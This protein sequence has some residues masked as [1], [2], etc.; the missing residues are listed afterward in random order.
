MRICIAKNE[1]TM[2]PKKS[3]SKKSPAAADPSTLPLVAGQD[4]RRQAEAQLSERKEKTASLPATEA[5]TQ[6]L[7]HELQVHQIELEMQ[8]EELVQARAEMEA[9]LRQYTDL[10]DFAPV[11]YFTLA[12]DGTISKVNLAG[13][14]LLGLEHGQLIM[15]RLGIFVCAQ[16]R[17][18]LSAF[19]D[20]VFSSGKKESCEIELLKAGSAPF[21]VY[22][23]AATDSTERKTCRAVVVDISERKQEEEISKQEQALSNAIIEAIPGTFY[24]LDEIGQYVRWNAYQRDEIVGKPDDLVGSTNAL[25]TIH[26]DDRALIQS[27]I[28]NVLAND[29][30]ETIEGRVLLR[31]GPAFRWLLMT[32]RRMLIDNR[33]FLVGI[34][35]DISARK[36]AEEA[37]QKTNQDYRMLSENSPDLIARFDT[38]LRHLYVNPAAAQ[39]GKLSADEYTGLTIAETGVDEPTA[40]IWEQRL[41]QVLDTGKM[42]D[43]VDSFPTPDGNHY[44]NTRFVPELAP[45]GSICSILSVARDIT[46]RKQAEE[47][48]AASEGELRAL[49]AAMT[50]V[51]IVYGADG[52][53]TKIALTNPINHYRPLDDMLGKTVHDILPKEQANYIVAKIDEAIQTGRVV[54]GEYT[55]QLGGKEIWFA[56]SASRLSENTAVWVA[57]DIT[58]RKQNEQKLREYSEHLEEMVAERTRELTDAQEKLVRQEKLAVLGQLAGGVGHELRNPLAVINAAIYYLKL[59]QPDASDKVRE[60][61]A[62]IE[63]EVRNS[64][65]IITDLLDFA[66]IKSVDREAVSVS[67]IVQRV[68][69]RYPVPPSVTLSL[70]LSPYLPKIYADPRH[71]EQVLGNLVLN[72]CQAMK[73]GGQ[74]SVISRQASV[75][76]DQLP[77]PNPQLLIIVRDTGVGISPENMSKLFEPLF[78]TKIKGIG[79]G[80]AISKKLIEANGGRIEVESEPGKGST[81]TLVLPAKED[82]R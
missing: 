16:S 19:L 2:S 28:V 74:L 18:T 11:G 41:R 54:T 45:D 5:D 3:L 30:D 72:A 59:V 38:N 64:E 69:E 35:I 63:Q 29:V 44:F 75:V 55:L 60:Y 34:G 21:W 47:K 76:S 17:T 31:G 46:E 82:K 56:A 78:T 79:L 13:A 4:L 57:H 77:I 43:V 62:M 8:N 68:L 42:L 33:P 58:E 65:K 26:P 39:S 61:H 22:I 15:R 40:A 32:G 37:L 81:F 9:V 1:E 71:V 52:R 10:Y 49:F 14:A 48:L 67:E 24:M 80:L 27:K 73:D 7:N 23:E 20:Q 66:R 51:V 6:R 53:Y 36:Q 50:D 12:R 70:D 25:D